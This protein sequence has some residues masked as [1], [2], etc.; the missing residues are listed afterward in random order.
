[1][2]VQRSW[3]HAELLAYLRWRIPEAI[4]GLSCAIEVVVFR[5]TY[6]RYCDRWP[7]ASFEAKW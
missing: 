2:I 7:G 6:L 1:M 5:P 4:D 3:E